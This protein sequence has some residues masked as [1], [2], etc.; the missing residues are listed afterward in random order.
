MTAGRLKIGSNF[1]KIGSNYLRVGPAS[2]G[3]PTGQVYVV[4]ETGAPYTI[5]QLDNTSYLDSISGDNLGN[6]VWHSRL[7]GRVFFVDYNNLGTSPNFTVYYGSPLATPGSFTGSYPADALASATVINNMSI[8]EGN[9][10]TIYVAGGWSGPSSIVGVFLQWYDASGTFIDQITDNQTVSGAGAHQ[11]I[12]SV[13]A[14]GNVYWARNHIDGLGNFMDISKY[15]PT[16]MSTPLWTTSPSVETDALCIYDVDDDG[17]SYI[18]TGDFS[19]FSVLRRLDTSGSVLS[20]IT[21]PSSSYAT[22]D[23]FLSRIALGQTDTGTPVVY[24]IVDSQGA[25]DLYL[26]VF[27]TDGTFIEN[28]KTA[29][30]SFGTALA[31]V[32]GAQHVAL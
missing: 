28:L 25:E 6:N 17:V 19:S 8:A 4:P 10:G 32:V 15:D 12:V 24:A 5:Y 2:T 21:V 18:W 30:L 23:Y 1:L 3:S 7:D 11:A 20:A 27:G 29:D 26:T 16:D 14:A 22:F 31:A 13:D 9:D